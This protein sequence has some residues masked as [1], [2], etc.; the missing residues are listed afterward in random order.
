MPAHGSPGSARYG[1]H[2]PRIRGG[3]NLMAVLAV[4]HDPVAGR[5]RQGP[6]DPSARAAD[7]KPVMEM[8]GRP[9]RITYKIVRGGIETAAAKNQPEAGRR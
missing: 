7:P 1:M 9:S 5:G 8:P 6:G 4:P 3:W 2:E